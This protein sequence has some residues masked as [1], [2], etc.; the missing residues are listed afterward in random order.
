MNQDKAPWRVN[1]NTPYGS[2]E[3][4]RVNEAVTLEVI[5]PS[6]ANDLFNLI[7]CNQERLSRFLA[8]PQ[9]VVSIEDTR[10][11][12]RKQSADHH[13]GVSKTYT[14]LYQG[15][16][17][18]ILSF[19]AID[20]AHQTTTIGYWI[21]ASLEG[22]G[23]ISA[24]LNKLIEHYSQA[25]IIRK[26]IINCGVTNRKS[27]ALAQRNGFHFVGVIQQVEQ[28]KDEWVDHNSYA[29]VIEGL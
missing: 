25:G 26:F 15:R 7:Q 10:A 18:G 17:S 5:Q 27:N 2:S 23:V 16:V 19:N 6:I 4:I 12:I 29:K 20:S 13:R 21:D 3:T 8:W 28:I 11:F 22:K 9:Q 14:M 24:A 1:Q